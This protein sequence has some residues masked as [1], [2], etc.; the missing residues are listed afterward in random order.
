MA[1]NGVRSE[2]D[3]LRGWRTPHE[4]IDLPD[5]EIVWVRALS[6]ADAMLLSEDD[7]TSGVKAIALGLSTES[8]QR[9][10]GAGNIDEGVELVSEWPAHRIEDIGNAIARL[11][12]TKDGA[13][14][15]EVARQDLPSAQP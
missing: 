8:G 10:F 4:R 14:P 15:V 11:S 12:H 7:A 3:R 1:N 6:A 2:I 13:D 5:G 9:L